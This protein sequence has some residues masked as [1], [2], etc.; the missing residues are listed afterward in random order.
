MI[1]QTIDNLAISPVHHSAETSSSRMDRI[2]GGSISAAG[3]RSSG[4][5]VDLSYMEQRPASVGR[6]R[7]EIASSLGSLNIQL[8]FS[9][10][11]SFGMPW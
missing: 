5:H 10:G 8:A 3:D 11:G 7:A 2:G 4:A 1:R 6:S 9:P